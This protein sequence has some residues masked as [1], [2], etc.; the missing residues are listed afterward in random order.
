V[1]QNILNKLAPSAVYTDEARCFDCSASGVLP[2]GICSLQEQAF[3]LTC[4]KRVLG[5]GQIMYFADSTILTCIIWALIWIGG[6]VLILRAVEYYLLKAGICKFS[7]AL[8]TIPF[9]VAFFWLVF[10]IAYAGHQVEPG[11][12]DTW[13]DPQKVEIRP[14]DQVIQNA[15]DRSEADKRQRL[16]Q[17][18]EKEQQLRKKSDDLMDQ[19]WEKEETQRQAENGATN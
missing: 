1:R 9:V 7:K 3:R 16:E 17:S 11:E 18:T 14:K 5:K 19:L 6:G 8:Y 2:P 4:I 12:T 15:Q 10:I 13:Q